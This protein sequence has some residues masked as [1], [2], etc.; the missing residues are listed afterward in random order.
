MND[1]HYNKKLCPL[2]VHNRIRNLKLP[3]KITTNLPIYSLSRLD[4]PNQVVHPSKITPRT[5]YRQTCRKSKLHEKLYR[6][7][8]YLP[9]IMKYNNRKFPIAIKREEERRWC[10]KPLNKFLLLI[11]TATSFIHSVFF[12]KLNKAMKMKGKIKLR[13]E[14]R[15]HDKDIPWFINIILFYYDF[16]CYS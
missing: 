4:K 14:K 2:W 16:H 10:K 15:E 13:E 11:R 5:R 6:G 3:Q 8:R 7:N 12:R 9:Y 1:K